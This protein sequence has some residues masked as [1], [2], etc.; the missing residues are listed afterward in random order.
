MNRKTKKILY[1]ILLAAALIIIL[2]LTFQDSAGTVRLSE[3]LRLWLKQFGIHTNFHSIRSNA[4]LIVY[5]LFGLVLSLFGRECGWNCWVILAVGA[6]VGLID[7]SIKV[8]L[9]TREFDLIDLFKDLIGVATAMLVIRLSGMKEN[10]RD[11]SCRC[12]HTDL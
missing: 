3:G 7:E 1:G 2:L 11:F 4:H 8:L 5:F 12:D 6:G 9:P 10:V